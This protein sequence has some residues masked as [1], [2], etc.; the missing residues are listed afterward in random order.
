[1]AKLQDYEL[2]EMYKDMLDECYDTVQIAGMTYLTSQ[3]LYDV[4]PITY[5]V[6]FNDW[7]DTLD[8]CEDCDQNPIECECEA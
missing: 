8:N 4:D 6:G 5:R 2:E 7:L 3:A 1:M